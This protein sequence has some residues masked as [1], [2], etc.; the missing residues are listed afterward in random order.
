MPK[1][2]LSIPGGLIDTAVADR[3]LLCRFGVA[4]VRTTPGIE[5]LTYNATGYGSTSING[6]SGTLNSFSDG[7]YNLM[8]GPSSGKFI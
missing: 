7:L 2:L 1:A 6:F 3:K 8:L 5:S 4:V